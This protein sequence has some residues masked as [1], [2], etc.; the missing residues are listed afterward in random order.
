MYFAA[1]AIFSLNTSTIAE[2]REL[3]P[4]RECVQRKLDLEPEEER[5]RLTRIVMDL[6]MV[7]GLWAYLGKAVPGAVVCAE[8]VSTL[9]LGSKYWLRARDR[10]R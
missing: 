1:T 10:I 4:T 3:V 6:A 2:V 7:S 8:R 5:A 9:S